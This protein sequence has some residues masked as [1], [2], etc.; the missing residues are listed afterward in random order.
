MH[1]QPRIRSGDYRPSQAV[2]QREG[3]ALSI[4]D[5]N[6]QLKRAASPWNEWPDVPPDQRP[7]RL[8]HAGAIG[9]SDQDI[10]KEKGWDPVDIRLLPNTTDVQRGEALK[11]CLEGIRLGTIAPDKSVTKFLELEARALGLT[12][13]RPPQEDKPKDSIGKASIGEIFGNLVDKAPQMFQPT[14][15]TG[16]PPGSKAKE[17]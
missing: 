11:A 2:W 4:I 6:E 9:K 5:I 10:L 8:P 1:Y 13:N 15:K 14:R 16:R 3:L 12:T 7:K 17:S